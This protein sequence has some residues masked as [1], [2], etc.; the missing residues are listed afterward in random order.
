[1]PGGYLLAYALELPL[2]WSRP[3]ERQ[4]SARS[5]PAAGEEHADLSADLQ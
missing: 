4:P 2:S 1:M 3:L 5:R